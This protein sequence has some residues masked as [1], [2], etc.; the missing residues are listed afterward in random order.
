MKKIF[1]K[2]VIIGALVVLALGLLFV[3]INFL[4]GVNVFKA[5]NYYYATY[6]NI[7]GMAQSA[8]VT[9]N[10]YK[11]GQVR[12]IIYD[13]DNLGNVTVEISVDKKLRIPRGSKALVVTDL[14]G[15]A[16]IE[17]VIGNSANGFYNIGDT[18]ESDVKA[19]MMDAVSKD[20]MP[21]VSAIFPKIDTLLTSLNAVASD[22]ALTAS[23]SR[24]DNITAELEASLRSMR[25]V[26]A[27]L[28]PVTR[29]VKSITA[30][31]DSITGDLSAV[32]ASLREAPL[33]SIISNLETTLANVEALTAQLNSPDSS[34]GKLTH[35]PELY[36]NLNSAVASLD[37]LF[38]D[39]KKNPKRYISIKLL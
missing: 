24:F 5:A 12:E 15:T 23:I 34:I 20:L 13:Y 18:L 25:G 11:I 6:T 10:G 31:V 17:L 38:I 26:L 27:S 37:S 28:Q 2:E 4:K 33:D 21:A 3:G 35:D 14:L 7:E 36:N 9:L 1:S 39:I 8:P 29:D 32:S 22:P 16:S 19:G 30:N